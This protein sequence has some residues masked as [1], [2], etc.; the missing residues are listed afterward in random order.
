MITP[1]NS[2]QLDAYGKAKNATAHNSRAEA[3]DAATQFEAVFLRQIIK[4]MRKSA[5]FMGEGLFGKSAGSGIKESWYDNM[6]A[7]HMSETG[8]VGLAT[9][10]VNDWERNGHIAKTPEEQKLVKADSDFEFSV[11]NN[12]LLEMNIQSRV[13]KNLP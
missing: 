3:K 1:S 10:L 5:E 11:H 7:T 2:V 8:N 6:L 13:L 4:D 12:Q 9:E